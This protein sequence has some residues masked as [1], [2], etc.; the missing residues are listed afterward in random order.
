SRARPRP[1]PSS[2]ANGGGGMRRSRNAGGQLYRRKSHRSGEALSTWTMV[3]MLDGKEVRESTGEIDFDL[4]QK[5]LRARM[6]A[7]DAG[8]YAGPDREQATVGE[9]LMGLLDYYATHKLGSLT[10]AT[11]QISTLRT[12]L[13][14]VRARDLTTARVRGLSRTWQERSSNAT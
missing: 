11:S 6:A 3:F 7:I 4:A 1:A 13:G 2:T 12:A 9:L 5:V 10:S 14:R 8:T